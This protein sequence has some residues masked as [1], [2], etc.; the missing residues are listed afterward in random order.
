[1][2]EL[3]EAEGKGTYGMYEFIRTRVR[4]TKD[5]KPKG[6]H[7]T[8]NSLKDLFER[9]D[10]D[11]EWFPGKHSDAKRGPK[12]IL[13]GGKKN[14]VIQAAK[15]IKRE[16]GEVTYSAIVAACPTAVVNPDTGEAVDKKLVY[17]VFKEDCYA[18]DPD[19][20]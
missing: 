16:D 4:K 14:A 17:T 1:M 8:V 9:I 11:P 6:D 2:R 15:R 13:I 20:R 10:S 18:D 19:D 12:R 3:W 5:K 7:P